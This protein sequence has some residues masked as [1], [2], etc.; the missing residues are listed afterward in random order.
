[1]D[2]RELPAPVPVMRTAETDLACIMTSCERERQAATGAVVLHAE[3]NFPSD[4]HRMP[5]AGPTFKSLV[6]HRSNGLSILLS[7][8]RVRIATLRS[9]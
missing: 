3:R 2:F 5:V 7:G 4:A 9:R 1:M 8:R 6:F